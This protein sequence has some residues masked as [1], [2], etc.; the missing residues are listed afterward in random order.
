M[1]IYPVIDIKNG[2]CVRT[3]KGQYDN[4]VVYSQF[5]EKFAKIWENEGAKFLH[6]IDLDG[7]VVGHTVND[8]VIKSIIQN[9]DIPVQVGGGIRTIQ[10]IEHTLALGAKKVVIGSKAAQSPAFVK[11][12]VNIFGSDRLVISIDAK[13]NMVMTDA[14]EKVSIYS[15]VSLAKLMKDI[16]ITTIVYTDVN[17]DGMLQGANIVF[18][19]ELIDAT[20][21]EVIVSGGTASLKDLEMLKDIGAKGVILGK[22]L[23]EHKINLKKAIEIFQ[24]S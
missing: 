22:S 9:I 12:A 8:E 4:L 17:R 24:E 11:E 23:Y 2:Q 13:D 5:P 3:R 18:A 19:K 7:A 15:T 16:G 20:G 21:L 10:D 14:W 6:I 1:F